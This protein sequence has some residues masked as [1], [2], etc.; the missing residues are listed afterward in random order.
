MKK[1]F[2]MF[3]LVSLLPMHCLASEL[4]ETRSKC[5]DY[6]LLKVCS[7]L[8]NCVNI[9]GTLTLNGT[10]INNLINISNIISS[11]SPLV[12][13]LVPFSSGLL[14]L[15]VDLPLG[16]PTTGILL[17]FGSSNLADLVDPGLTV[18]NTGYA[19]SVPRA[20]TL[21]DLRVSVDSVYAIGAPST[22]F[23]LTFTII[24]SSCT[25]GTLTPYTATALAATATTTAP[26]QPITILTAGGAGCGSSATSIPVAAGDRVALLV[27]PNIAIPITTL[28]TLSL[29]A[30]VLYSPAL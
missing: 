21:H 19:F 26:A 1:I 18:T 24:V 9:N 23:S 12:N 11:G 25:A 30:G 17:G 2:H 20:G 28:A 6:K 5:K 7:L 10:N 15:G 8:A 22:P 3:M 14:T 29:S 4:T 16:L 13:S 27:T